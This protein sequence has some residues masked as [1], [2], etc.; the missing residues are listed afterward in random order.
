MDIANGAAEKMRRTAIQFP[1][2]L[3]AV[4]LLIAATHPACAARSDFSRVEKV[5]ETRVSK[6]EFM[7]A[8]LI[9]RGGQ[10]LFS[11]GFGKANMEWGV[12]NSPRTRFKLGSV[13]KQFTAA[14]ILLLQERGRLKLEDPISKYMAEVPPAWQP[15]TFLNLLTHTSGIPDL[16]AFPDFDATE[17]FPTTPEKLVQRFVAKPLDFPPGAGFRYSNSGY[18]L[19]GYLLERITGQTYQQFIQRNI[20]DPLGMKDSGYDSNGEIIARHAAGYAPSKRGI[21]VAG[22]VDMTIPFSAGGLYSTTE[23]LLRWQNGLYGGKLLTPESL[24]K[25]TTP[26]K[27]DYAFGVAVDPDARGNS[28]I[29]HNG[30]IEGFGASLVYVP[31]ERLSI[32]VLSNL[33]GSSAR[34]V[35]D[36][37]LKISNHE[38][39]MPK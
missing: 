30:A 21:V 29:W 25:M 10:V 32:V 22:Y 26:F 7:G 8:V 12:P 15:I 11:K 9:A 31:A 4:A 14:A 33:E 38:F 16:T 20:F 17:P 6:G 18:I 19:L 2:A 36:D 27:N 5:L 23:D 28:V 35:R 24:A 3:G 1:G 13:T 37:I 39:T 34:D